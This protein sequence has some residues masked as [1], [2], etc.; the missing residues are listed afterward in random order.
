MASFAREIT[1]RFELVSIRALYY[2]YLFILF[3]LFIYLF[4]YSTLYIYVSIY[5]YFI[6][7]LSSFIAMILGIRLLNAK[8]LVRD[9]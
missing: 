6:A 5:I 3:I 1:Y 7:L 4:I 8:G 2:S 9:L